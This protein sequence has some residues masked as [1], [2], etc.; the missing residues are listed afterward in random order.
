MGGRGVYVVWGTIR[1][2]ASPRLTSPLLLNRRM[3]FPRACTLLYQIVP[4]WPEPFHV[5]VTGSSTRAG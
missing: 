1:G 4:A 3:A 5:T 2:H